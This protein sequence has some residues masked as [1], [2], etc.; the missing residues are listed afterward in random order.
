MHRMST[1]AQ[2]TA[3]PGESRRERYAWFVL[4]VLVAVYGSNFVDRYIFIILM[5][6][7]KQDLRLL[8]AARRE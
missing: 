8:I 4:V 7:I 5:E 6:P 1:E 3:A 2:V